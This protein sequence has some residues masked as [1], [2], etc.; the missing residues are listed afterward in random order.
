MAPHIWGSGNGTT[1][2]HPTILARIIGPMRKTSGLGVFKWMEKEKVKEGLTIA[3]GWCSTAGRFLQRTKRKRR[4][5]L[6]ATREI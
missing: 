3:R 4:Q 5:T 1:R 2:L 6:I